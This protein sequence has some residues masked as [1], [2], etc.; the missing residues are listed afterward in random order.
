MLVWDRA[1][2]EPVLREWARWAPD[3]PDDVTTAFR[4]LNLPPLPDIPEMLRGR[5][6]VVIDGAVLGS[7]AQGE[8]AIAHLRALKPEIDTFARV[9]AR[10]LV[11]LHMDPEGPTPS[12]ADASMLG[13]FTDEAVDAFLAEVGP[14]SSSS[15]LL[16]E[17]RQLGGALGRRHEDG[18]ALD[19]LDAAF[20]S[21]GL[22]IAATPEMAE[23][24]EVDAH[25]FTGAL[26]PWANGRNYLNFSE[27]AVD[28]R[29]GYDER[30]WLQ[31]KG[32]RSAVDP[33]GLFVGN[34]RIPRLVEHGRVTD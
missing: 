30:A 11:R 14:G 16:A 32:I 9:P 19:R 5:S 22:A 10:S 2:A 3:A 8:A 17:L 28:P 20:I 26:S 15:L 21:F 31:L 13:S 4:V 24:G 1:H 34:H 29:S 27:N 18:G 23:R 6:V 12:V 33:D 7:D 25:R